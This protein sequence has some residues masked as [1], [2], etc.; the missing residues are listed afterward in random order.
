VEVLGIL[1]NL[2]IPDFD[3]EKFISCYQI[4]DFL[5][6]IIKKYMNADDNTT[7]EFPEGL[8]ENDDIL[9]QC[10]IL[11]GTLSFDDAATTL[12]AKSPI[13]DLL[14]DVLVMKEEDDEII[15]QVCYCVY[16]YL[17]HEE[18]RQKLLSVPSN[19]FLFEK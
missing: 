16:L 11:I 10:L 12:V 14:V 17:L 19:S 1:G 4:L 8:S 9:L 2:K 15:L 5:V 3:Y 6:R 18:P 7:G 13:L